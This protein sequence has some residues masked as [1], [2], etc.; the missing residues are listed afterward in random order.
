[1]KFI[2]KT[3][4]EHTTPLALQQTA[5]CRSVVIRAVVVDLEVVIEE[6]EVRSV[7]E[8]EV[9]QLEKIKSP[10]HKNFRN[11]QTDRVGMV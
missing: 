3:F 4:V 10:A 8:V 7:E 6:G 1:M 11:G 9:R 2:S 5:R